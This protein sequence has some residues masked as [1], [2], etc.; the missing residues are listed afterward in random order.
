MEE[1]IQVVDCLSDAKV[2]KLLE[3]IEV[4]SEHFKGAPVYHKNEEFHVNTGVRSNTC[5]SVDDSHYISKVLHNG[6]RKGLVNYKRSLINYHSSYD[7]FPLPNAKNVS[8]KRENIQILRYVEGQQ[9]LWHTDQFPQ[10]DHNLHARELSVVLYLT[11]DF[12]G[13]RTCLPCGCYKP[14]P[15]QALVFP[16]NWCFP[17]S[18]EPVESGTKIVSVAWFHAHYAE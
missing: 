6:M 8:I 2:N 5:F 7:S 12:T 16:S 1:L 10:R 3:A 4:E 9:Y 14:A 13:G 17:H 15:G 11:N 18:A